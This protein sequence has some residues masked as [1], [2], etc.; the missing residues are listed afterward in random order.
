MAENHGGVDAIAQIPSSVETALRRTMVLGLPEDDTQKPTFHFDRDVTWADHDSADKPWDW[1]DAPTLDNTPASVQ[2]ICAMEFFAPL[3]R[4][5]AQY[6]EVGDFFPSTV[7][8]TFTETDYLTVVN[9]SY[10]TM[11]P[12]DTRYWFRYWRPTVGLGTLTVYQA[13]F[14]AQDTA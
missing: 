11:G 7:I 1:T 8:V 2:P 12:A 4:T 10:F 6:T 13:H 5:G 3:G 9:S 14:E